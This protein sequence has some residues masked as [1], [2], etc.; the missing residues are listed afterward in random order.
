MNKDRRFNLRM[1]Q[2]THNQLDELLVSLKATPE[3]KSKSK[4]VE[5]AIS[6]YHKKTV[7]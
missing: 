7:K 5:D 6:L 1:H 3:G 4:I 2:K